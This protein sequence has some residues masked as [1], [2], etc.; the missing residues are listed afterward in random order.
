M[1]RYLDLW[2]GSKKDKSLLYCPNGNDHASIPYLV[3]YL[4]CGLTS[5]F[6][7]VK[8]WPGTV[9]FSWSYLWQDIDWV[10]QI[11]HKKVVIGGSAAKYLDA[12]KELPNYPNVQFW[13]R[14]VDFP[15]TETRIIP[16]Y[17]VVIK[18]HP[19]VDFLKVY[20]GYGCN[21]G[22]CTFCTWTNLITEAHTQFDPKY[23]ASIIL[24]ANSFGKLAGLSAPTHTVNWLEKVEKYLPGNER[25]YWCY[26]NAHDNDWGKLRKVKEI[27]IGSE[28]FS[29]SVLQR[30]KKGVTAEKII[31]AIEDILKAGINVYSTIIEDLYETEEELHEHLENK[32]RLLSYTAPPKLGHGKLWLGSCR[33]ISPNHYETDKGIYNE[34]I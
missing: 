10:C 32:L 21:W 11:P 2:D 27:F 26:A 12:K 14:D 9:L 24:H 30:I 18:S 5:S 1:E 31:G 4:D 15:V 7:E 16:S 6:E 34:N 17:D 29:D 19:L 25:R 22:K 20:S 28:Y 33:L 23:I 13:F 8:K 3:A